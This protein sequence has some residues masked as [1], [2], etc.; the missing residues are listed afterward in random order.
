MKPMKSANELRCAVMQIKLK[1]NFA[2]NNFFR[3]TCCD[4]DAISSL[5]K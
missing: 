3:K 2:L 1:S 4:M 5:K